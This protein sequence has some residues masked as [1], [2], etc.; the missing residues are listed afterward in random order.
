MTS[1]ESVAETSAKVV[2][3]VC[4]VKI[5]PEKAAGNQEYEGQ[6]YYFCGRSCAEKFKGDP[7]SF[8]TPKAKPS[9]APPITKSR[10]HLPNGP[11]GEQAG[12]GKLPEVRYGARTCDAGCAYDP[13]AVHLPDAPSDRA[14]G[15]GKL[16]HLWHDARTARVYGGRK[17]S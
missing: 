6:T 10:V 5:L 11:G 13:H 17:E 9:P 8:V 4:G 2:D 12:A 15:T 14:R 1:H 3:P 7:A 16:P